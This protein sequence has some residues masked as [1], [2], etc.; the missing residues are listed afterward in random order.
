MVLSRVRYR[1]F[2]VVHHVEP[3]VHHA[4]ILEAM[5]LLE[6]V[7][8][9]D[10]A[11]VQDRAPDVPIELVRDVDAYVVG[12]G[13]ALPSAPKLAKKLLNLMQWTRQLLSAP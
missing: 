2:K 8:R 6:L 12:A 5:V 9:R 13:A 1:G 7:Q 4:Q 11:L 3:D 10:P